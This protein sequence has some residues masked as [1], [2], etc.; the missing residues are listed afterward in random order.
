MGIY[1]KKPLEVKAF[2]WTGDPKQTE[3]PAWITKAIKDNRIAFRAGSPHLGIRPAMII[4][5][6]EGFT[7]ANRGD[8]II[9]DKQ[10]NIYPCKPDEF[11]ENYEFVSEEVTEEE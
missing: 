7:V 9:Q 2:R 6:P 1:K 11:K 4:C 8:Y 5:S 3:D 10:G